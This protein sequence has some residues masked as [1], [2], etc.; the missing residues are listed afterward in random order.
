[1]S[2]SGGTPTQKIMSRSGGF[3][4]NLLTTSQYYRWWTSTGTQPTTNGGRTAGIWSTT[5]EAVRKNGFAIITPFTYTTRLTAQLPSTVCPAIFGS[6]VLG[7][8]YNNGSQNSTSGGGTGSAMAWQTTTVG[9]SPSGALN[10][11]TNSYFY[12]KTNF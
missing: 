10:H 4:Y 1:M 3:K 2:S 9:G 6:L 5:G 8:T 11:A 7:V 12:T